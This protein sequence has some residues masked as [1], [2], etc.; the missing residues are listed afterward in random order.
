MT[1]MSGSVST[2]GRG[3]LAEVIASRGGKAAPEAPF[4]IEHREALIYM[5]CEA[6]ELEH[7]IMCQYLFAAFSLKQREDEGLT[8]D[9]LEA[10]RRWRH[11][12]AHVAT[13]EMLHLAL[14][15]NLL[16]AIGAAPHLARPNLPAPARHY[17]AGVNLTLVPFGEPALRHFMFLERPEG[18]ELTGAEGID[19]PVHEAV[20]LLAEGDIVPQPQDFATVGHLYR[21]IEHGLDHLAEKFGE[22][23]LFLGPPRAQ[24]T[25]EY[26]HWPELVSVTDLASAHRAIDTI[27]EQGEGARGH[28]QHAHF[29]Q[30]VRILDEY[31]QLKAANPD[32]APARPVVFATVRPSQHDD[33]VPRITEDVAS[34]CTDLFNVGYEVLLQLLH[35]YFAHTEETDTQLATLSNAA[36]ALMVGV[37]KPLGDLITTLPVG[38]EHPGMT[39]GPSFELFYEND[40]L[41]PHRE[42]AWALL[43]E[44]LREAANFCDLIQESSDEGV[45]TELENVRTAL[46]GVADSLAGHFGDWGAMSRFAGGKAAKEST[47]AGDA[48]IDRKEQMADRVT[49]EQD[50]RKLFR[51]RDIQ[52]MSFAFDLSSYE[53]VRAN[54]E[55]IYE[56]LAE[57][58]M[59]C[60]GRWPAEDVERFRTWIDNGSPR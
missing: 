34:R 56:K 58:S 19:A 9:V 30:F 16:S 22:R 20:P 5:L 57:G 55:A 38:P 32:L 17:P 1:E 29:G 18:M 4:M 10:V 44:R 27:L 40:Y 11:A 49:Y 28:W 7:G 24:A 25:S 2:A 31:R 60:D 53:D 33:T 12:I 42:A 46:L 52:S 51:D 26:F 48:A 14:V 23:N 41:M 45:A 59:P 3:R 54:A 47:A 6:A 37:L 50:I 15:Q 36:I 21:S 13:E 39:A 35:R 8:A 43:E